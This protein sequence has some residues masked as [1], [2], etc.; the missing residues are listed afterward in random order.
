MGL[1]SSGMKSNSTIKCQLI[2][3]F[4]FVKN[5]NVHSGAYEDTTEVYNYVVI[6]AFVFN[7]VS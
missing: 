4:Y 6:V 2:I 7:D 3:N 5:T 1:E